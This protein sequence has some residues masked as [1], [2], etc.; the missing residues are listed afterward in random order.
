MGKCST[1]DVQSA[2][3]NQS[4]DRNLIF[5][6]RKYE[7]GSTNHRVILLQVPVFNTVDERAND[8]SQVHPPPV[9]HKATP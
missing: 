7:V 6:H 4:A 1:E 3:F 9:T 8:T 2:A 5:P